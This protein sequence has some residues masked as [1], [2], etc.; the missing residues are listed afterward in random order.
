[1]FKRTILDCPPIGPLLSLQ[2]EYT[3]KRASHIFAGIS[4]KLKD[5]WEI[6]NVPELHCQQDCLGIYL[7]AF[8]DNLRWVEKILASLN[9]G[10]HCAG[11]YALKQEDLLFSGL[12]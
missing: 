9:T 11:F 1:M 3:S 10:K 4:I 5:A 2:D 6:A 7:K 12:P 8:M